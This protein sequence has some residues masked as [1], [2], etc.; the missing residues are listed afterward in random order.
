MIL[1]VESLLDE[2]NS[3]LAT[4]KEKDSELEE[5]AI[6]LSSLRKKGKKDEN[7]EQTLSDLWE[8]V[9]LSIKNPR[10]RGSGVEKCLR[11]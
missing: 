4:S 10:K 11:K 9:K 8:T 6:E 3:K 7:K 5:K 1:Q 2:L